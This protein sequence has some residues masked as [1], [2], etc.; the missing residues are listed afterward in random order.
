MERSA[1]YHLRDERHGPALSS[2]AIAEPLPG[3]TWPSDAYCSCDWC[4]E[5]RWPP[6]LDVESDD[7]L[8]TP[9]PA[10]KPKVEGGGKQE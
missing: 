8:E 1:Y 5:N 3:C 4:W 6:S 7:G 9:P 10:K 2:G